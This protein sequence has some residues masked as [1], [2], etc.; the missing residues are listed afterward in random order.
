MRYLIFILVLFCHKCIAAIIPSELSS[1]LPIRNEG[2]NRILSTSDSFT[3]LIHFQE[4]SAEL[5]VITFDKNHKLHATKKDHCKLF[6]PHAV[7]AIRGFY[8]IHKEAVLFI[9]QRIDNKNVLLR[10][11]INIYSGVLIEETTLM[12]SQLFSYNTYTVLKW[13]DLCYV[14]TMCINDQHNDTVKIFKYSDDYKLIKTYAPNFDNIDFD[15]IN[16]LNAEIDRSGEVCFCIML[17][18]KQPFDKQKNL[19]KI[20]YYDIYQR[21]ERYKA[22]YKSWKDDKYENYDNALYTYL[23]DKKRDEFIQTR[24]KLPENIYPFYTHFIYDSS[25]GQLKLLLTSSKVFY[26]QI[27]KTSSINSD[28]HSYLINIDFRKND[29][30]I[31]PVFVNDS[32]SGANTLP[33]AF[34]GSCSSPYV[35]SEED[36][37]VDAHGYLGNIIISGFAN[38]RPTVS[39]PITQK[40]N[41]LI[42]PANLINKHSS[43]MLNKE[44]LTQEYI[45]QYASFD[46]FNANSSL[47]IIYNDYPDNFKRSRDSIIPVFQNYFNNPF[48]ETD[49]FVYKVNDDGRVF[50][51]RI[52]DHLS[53]DETISGMIQCGCF[54]D[55]TNTYA[56]VVLHKN[57]KKMNLQIA[58]IKL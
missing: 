24:F 25:A 37:F 41:A 22:I 14:V 48:E 51:Q 27:A 1:A 52:F 30:T 18:K 8:E 16:S 44:F 28:Y 12:V 46:Y 47:Y 11:R 33:L 42:F 35:I 56:T 23:L 49:L 39:L 34:S 29:F 40:L 15:N 6:N 7:N 5:T 58:W 45:N 17:S 10:L 50:K 3:V 32:S 36:V 53:N 20:S 57:G 21:V 13:N 2:W 26:Y 4:N 19:K 43:V 54:D 31:N 9:E 55:K 38:Q